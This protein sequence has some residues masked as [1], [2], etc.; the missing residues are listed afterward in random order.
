MAAERRVRLLGLLLEVS[1]ELDPNRMCSV[2]AELTGTSGAGLMLMSGD[3]V[4]GSVAAT[5][6]ASALIED[7]QFALGEGP[8]VDAYH[9][10]RPVLEPDL[11][12]PAT[13]RW[14]AFTDAVVDAGVCAIFGFPLRLGQVRLGALD[15]YRDRPGPLS[16]EQHADA[17]AMADI[18]TRMVLAMQAIAPS[19]QLAMGLQDGDLQYVV[20]QASGMVAAQLG[21]SVTQALIRLKAY[22]FG[23]AQPLRV[24]AEDVVERR[25]RFA[26]GDGKTQV[27]RNET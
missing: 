18:A 8:C 13:V 14:P 22:A 9:Q 5:N 27:K 16:D 12:N 11:A 21:V 1:S 24:V 2:G 15:L 19:D 6:A 7:V 26:D 10:D 25:L 4:R 3:V 23:N 20:H 17:L